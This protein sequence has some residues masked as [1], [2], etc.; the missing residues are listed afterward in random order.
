MHGCHGNELSDWS[1]QTFTFRIMTKC[2]LIDFKNELS[3]C[4]HVTEL[5][6]LISNIF[7]CI[8]AGMHYR[9]VG[10]ATLHN[11]LLIDDHVH[12]L[13]SIK[14]DLPVPPTLVRLTQSS[15]CTVCPRT[16]FDV[17]M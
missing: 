1:K 6:M 17:N 16:S 2:S 7:G 11:R 14:K 4:V 10:A 13:A 12:R 8:Y 5:K 9:Q 15:S 3:F